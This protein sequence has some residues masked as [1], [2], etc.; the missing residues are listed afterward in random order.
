MSEPYNTASCITESPAPRRKEISAQRR[1]QAVPFVKQN[2]VSVAIDR[3]ESTA[4]IES[5]LR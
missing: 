3:R 2:F 5:V 1:N 4:W